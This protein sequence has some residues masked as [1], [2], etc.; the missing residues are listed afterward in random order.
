MGSEEFGRSDRSKYRVNTNLSV[1][2]TGEVREEKNLSTFSKH[3]HDCSFS[4][5]LA[6]CELGATMLCL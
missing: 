5:C 4:K 2:Q 3:C 6:K 1:A